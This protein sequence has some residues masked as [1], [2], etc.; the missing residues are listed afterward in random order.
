MNA[1]RASKASDQCVGPARERDFHEGQVVGIGQRHGRWRRGDAL[2]VTLELLQHGVDFRASNAK[3]G[4]ESTS[5]Y[6]ARMRSSR[7]K[8]SSPASTSVSTRAGAPSG[9]R[10]ADTKTLVS[11]TILTCGAWPCALP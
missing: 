7:S 2:A 6:S 8:V 5:R 9:E 1:A 4:R 10:N 11:R 3:R